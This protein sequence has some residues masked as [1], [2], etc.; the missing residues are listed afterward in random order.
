MARDS[1]RTTNKREILK[2]R[3]NVDKWRTKLRTRS[4]KFGHRG[5]V[6]DFSAWFLRQDGVV[7]TKDILRYCK[8]LPVIWISLNSYGYLW[9]SS[10]CSQTDHRGKFVWEDN[11]LRLRPEKKFDQITVHTDSKSLKSIVDLL[12]FNIIWSCTARTGYCGGPINSQLWRAQ[13]QLHSNYNGECQLSDENYER[14]RLNVKD[15][16]GKFETRGFDKWHC[17]RGSS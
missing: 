13:L 14:Q 2:R 11:N 1:K 8:S 10:F 4:W 3:R 15:W 12:R 7:W 9:S 5:Q 16:I 17:A 6:H